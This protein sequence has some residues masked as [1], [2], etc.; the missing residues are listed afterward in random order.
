LTD[1]TIN[2]GAFTGH[3]TLSAPVCPTDPEQL[4]PG[5]KVVCTAEYTVVAADLTGEPLSNTATVTVTPPNGTPV[6]SDPSTAR[7]TDVLDPTPTG[8]SG[9]PLASTGSTIAWGVGGVALAL[10]V[11]GGVLLLIR[12]RRSAA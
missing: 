1:P 11:A 4:L 12:R 10:V 5:Q 2:E 7:I 6:T 9:D 8:T 3:G